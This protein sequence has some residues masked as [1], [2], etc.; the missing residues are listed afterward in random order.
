MSRTEAPV[1]LGKNR[2]I[3]PVHRKTY[4]T[5]VKELS[6]ENELNTDEIIDYAKG[7]ANV[8]TGKRKREQPITKAVEGLGYLQ[9]VK[10]AGKTNEK[11]KKKVKYESG[12]VTSTYSKPISAVRNSQRKRSITGK[13]AHIAF[14]EVKP[15]FQGQGKATKLRKK[16]IEKH[17]KEGYP[18]STSMTI[19]PQ[20]E[21]M[22]KKYGAT[23]YKVEPGGMGNSEFNKKWVWNNRDY[24]LNMNAAEN[25]EEFWVKSTGKKLTGKSGKGHKLKLKMKTTKGSGRSGKKSKFI[26]IH[27]NDSK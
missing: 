4:K 16:T 26:S 11:T 13:R 15:E 23:V 27:A 1:H 7:Y 19:Q 21:H 10:N 8:W 9:A 24:L 12:S 25:K 2:Y 22:N 6:K 17:L 20:T 18:I 3:A 5:T 14:T